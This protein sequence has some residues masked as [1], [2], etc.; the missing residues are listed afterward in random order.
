MIEGSQPADI[1]NVEAE[2]GVIASVLMNPE[3]TFY[4]EQLKPNHFT[5]PIN[6]YVYWA[7]VELAKKG[8]D[9]VDA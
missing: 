8:I 4:S 7:V 6:A 1:K 9:K 5:D 3:L 2:A